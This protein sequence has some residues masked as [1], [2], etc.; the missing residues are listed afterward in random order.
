MSKNISLKDFLKTYT[1]ISNKFIDEYYKF[2]EM[3]EINKFGIEASKVIKYLELDSARFFY[4]RL[5]TRFTLKQDYIIKR[6]KQKSTENVKDTFYYL[7][8]DGFEKVCMTSRSKKGNAVRDYFITLRKFIEYYRQHFADNINKMAKG[9]KCIYIILANKNKNIF[10]VGRSKDIRKR[11]YSYATGKDKH[12]DIMF[13]ML[14]DDPKK[15]EDCTKIFTTKNIVREKQ[16]LYK[17][18]FD[19]LKSIIFNCAFLTKQF[20][21]VISTKTNN[22]SID[23]YIVYDEGTAEY[24]DNNNNIIGLEKVIK[25][26][27]KK[28]SK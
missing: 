4:E 25:K 3:C 10:K 12:P 18:D 21:D 23:S 27:S 13:I 7:S 14:I 8:F 20:N 24:I 9:E 26:T 16:E 17:I 5:R 28:A 19:T 2:Y 15:V 11:L 6:L 1:A 22:N